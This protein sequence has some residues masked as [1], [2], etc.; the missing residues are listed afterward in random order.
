MSC[1]VNQ[2]I[3][4]DVFLHSKPTPSGEGILGRFL[5]EIINTTPDKGLKLILMAPKTVT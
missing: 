1:A 2:C 4:H 3:N 5:M